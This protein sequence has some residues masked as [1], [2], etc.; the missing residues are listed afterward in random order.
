[1][2]YMFFSNAAYPSFTINIVVL[3]WHRHSSFCRLLG[4]SFFTLKVYN[5]L[6]RCHT[7]IAR[8]TVFSLFFPSEFSG[9]QR[10]RTIRTER[11]LWVLLTF[12]R[13]LSMSSLM[14]SGELVLK[15][16]PHEDLPVISS[17]NSGGRT[18]HIH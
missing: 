13:F 3:P 14:V 10:H 17:W 7:K 4:Y 8:V 5:V 6:E 1:M 9:R 16:F 15:E 12:V 11:L 18:S 2:V